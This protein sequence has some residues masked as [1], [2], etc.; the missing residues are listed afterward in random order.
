MIAFS[1]VPKRLLINTIVLLLHL[2]S[3]PF[4]SFHLHK[5]FESFSA[6]K[7]QLPA[8]LTVPEPFKTL[9]SGDTDHIKTMDKGLYTSSYLCES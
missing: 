2:A 9:H 5:T 7:L 4:L 1:P 3:Y 8:G 6:L